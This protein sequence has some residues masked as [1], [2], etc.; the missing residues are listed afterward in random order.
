M[1]ET[2]LINA[3]VMYLYSQSYPGKNV[4][5]SC[6]RICSWVEPNGSCGKLLKSKGLL[7]HS[8]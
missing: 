8:V 4:L 6:T 1:F 3:R 5:K 2:G 7:C